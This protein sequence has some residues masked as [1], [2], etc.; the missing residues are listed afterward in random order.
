ML[1]VSRVIVWWVIFEDHINLSGFELVDNPTLMTL[2][3]V[4]H[5][6]FFIIMKKHKLDAIKIS[7]LG[8]QITT[9]SHIYC[10]DS[11]VPQ[12]QATTDTDKENG[13]GQKER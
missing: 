11:R 4:L 8:Y 6:P 2:K 9:L 3:W 13:K 5:L 7:I 12:V 10:L 1:A